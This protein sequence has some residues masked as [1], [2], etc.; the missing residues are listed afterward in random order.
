MFHYKLVN[1]ILTTNTFLKIINVRDDDKCTFCKQG[2]ETLSHLFWEC[3]EVQ[4]FITQVTSHLK[5]QYQIT[6]QVDIKTWFFLENL[7][8]IETL[9]ITLVKLV[10]YESRLGEKIPNVT[11]FKNKLKR[12]AEIEK[13]AAMLANKKEKFEAKWGSIERILLESGLPEHTT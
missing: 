11:H 5:S 10:I 12:E 3:I 8:A 13:T 1:R 6:L 7:S 9:I 4:T 2:V